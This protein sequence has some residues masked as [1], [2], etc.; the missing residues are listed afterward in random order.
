MNTQIPSPAEFSN[1][2]VTGD[3]KKRLQASFN[4][5]EEGKYQPDAVYLSGEQSNQWDGDTEGRTILALALLAQAGG[6]EPRYLAEIL[7]RYPEKAN[8]LGYLGHIYPPGTAC[9]QQLSGHGWLLRGL[10]ETYLW[11]RDPA[12]LEILARIIANLV[13]PTAGL[14]RV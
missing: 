13:L 6:R 11:R 10:C 3:L 1:V 2:T 8:A 14:H 5:L 7:R 4:R 9:E 12:L